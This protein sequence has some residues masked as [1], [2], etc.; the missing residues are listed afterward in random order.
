MELEN[1]FLKNILVELGKKVSREALSLKRPDVYLPIQEAGFKE[2]DFGMFHLFMS[3][4]SEFTEYSLRQ[5][6]L[7]HT[8]N[9]RTFTELSLKLQCNCH[10]V[11]VVAMSLEHK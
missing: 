2:Q 5:T 9:I 11:I 7:I 10:I 1:L 8:F 4:K 6:M 3:L